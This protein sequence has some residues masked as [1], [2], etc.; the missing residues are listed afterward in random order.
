[1][2]AG[3]PEYGWTLTLQFLGFKP[4]TQEGEVMGFA[5]YGNPADEQEQQRV[6]KLSRLMDEY[7]QIDNGTIKVNEDFLYY[8]EFSEG[9]A[10]V[11]P[12][13]AA[14]HAARQACSANSRRA[15]RRAARTGRSG[16]HCRC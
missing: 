7:V 16:W 4:N 9:R 2:F 14:S 12:G 5:A 1:M 3:D 15:G 8:G 6:D 10:R 13:K 11:S